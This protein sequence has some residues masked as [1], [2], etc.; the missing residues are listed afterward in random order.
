[1]FSGND[2]FR[3]TQN[4]RWQKN[5]EQE[6][7]KQKTSPNTINKFIHK[8]NFKSILNYNLLFNEKGQI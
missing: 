2:E 5:H 7:Q 4:R 3:K 6:N 8:L 1:M